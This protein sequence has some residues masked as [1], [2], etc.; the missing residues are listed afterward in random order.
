MIEAEAACA[1]Y[2][3]TA[4]ARGAR[5]V[6]KGYVE[7]A[8]LEHIVELYKSKIGPNIGALASGSARR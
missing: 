4:I 6:E 2:W 1:M 5:G 3:H 7:T 8:A